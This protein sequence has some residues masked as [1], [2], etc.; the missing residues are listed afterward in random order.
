MMPDLET[1]VLPSP[2]L[3]PLHLNE[4]AGNPS[5]GVS[6]AFQLIAISF[7][8]G[9]GNGDDARAGIRFCRL[10]RTEILP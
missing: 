2:S 7:A 6:A 4:S 5:T 3:N 10:Q 9:K 8:A 1:G